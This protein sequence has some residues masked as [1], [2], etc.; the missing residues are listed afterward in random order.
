[1]YFRYDK[2][3][4]LTG[5]NLNGTEYIYV[6]NAQGDVTGILDMDGNQIVSYKYD[7]WGKVESIS[8]SQASTV[9][10]QNPMRYRGYY[11]DAETGFYYLQ[12]RYYDAEVGRFVSVDE[13]GI[14]AGD[15]E[16][17]NGENLFSYCNNKPVSMSDINGYKGI[18]ITNKLLNLMRINAIKFFYY[19]LTQIMYNGF[20]N[21][22][23]NSFKY[24]YNNSKS[25]GSWDLKSYNEWKLSSK[26][27]FIFFGKRLRNDDP[28]NIHFGYVGSVMFPLIIL[29]VGAGIYQL[30]SGTSSV[31]FVNSFFDD[32]RDSS[33]IVLGNSLY[34]RDFGTLLLTALKISWKIIY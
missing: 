10:A 9:G 24:F 16:S 27:W 21:G 25:G 19:I 14:M 4:S 12:S 18:D 5:F 7:A 6:K 13:P 32:P 31:R 33:M 23:K 8:G 28:G 34:N 29:R 15:F 22:L 3:G 17:F 20:I 11:E 26:D 1:M 2:N 30:Y